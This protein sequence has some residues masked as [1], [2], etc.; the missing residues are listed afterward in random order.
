MEPNLPVTRGFYKLSVT[1]KV[2]P[3]SCSDSGQV[4]GKYRDVESEGKIHV[5]MAKV[6]DVKQITHV[7]ESLVQMDFGLLFLREL[8]NN[9]TLKKKLGRAKWK[10]E[11]ID[12]H[13]K[14][15]RKEVLD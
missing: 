8:R 4:F 1:A 10:A 3:V 9:P 11:I 5:M 7:A 6:R 15:D 14:I 12:L 13:F 2:R